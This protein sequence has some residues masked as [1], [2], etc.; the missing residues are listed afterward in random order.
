[1]TMTLV[2]E[3]MPR[4]WQGPTLENFPGTDRA[5]NAIF[6]RLGTDYVDLYIIHRF[7]P[8]TPKGEIVL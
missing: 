3:H 4:K 1:M 7:D 5:P 6:R 2:L 8:E